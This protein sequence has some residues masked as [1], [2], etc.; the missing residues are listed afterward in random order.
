MDD[1][2]LVATHGILM[3]AERIGL[4]IPRSAREVP[5]RPGRNGIA[6]R[7]EGCGRK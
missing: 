3:V 4:A 5:R 7:T 2:A 1:D 6:L